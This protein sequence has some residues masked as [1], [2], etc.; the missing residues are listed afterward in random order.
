MDGYRLL[1]VDREVP[2]FAF[3]RSVIISRTDYDAHGSAILAHEQ[4]HIHLNHFFDLMLL[5]LIKTIHWFNPVVYALIGDLKEIHEFQADEHTL[6][7]GID[8]TQYQKLIIQKG[9]GLQRFALANSF[10]HC[11]IKK[12]IT[13]MNKSKNSKAWRWKVVTF[14]PLLALLLMAFGKPGENAQKI[15][16]PEIVQKNQ[17]DSS[18]LSIEIR[19]DGYFIN[20][21]L[22][23]LEEISRRAELW[24]KNNKEEVLILWLAVP[25][26]PNGLSE[27]KAALKKA[28]IKSID[29][30]VFYSGET[31]VQK[32]DAVP[33]F[34]GGIFAL[35][36]WIPQNIIYPNKPLIK[37]I[38]GN[39]YVNF[40]INA[41]GRVLDP[42][43]VKGIDPDLD[44]EALRIVS[45][46]PKWK[47]GLKN[48][49]AINVN[50]YMPIRVALKQ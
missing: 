24:Q 15:S 10:N 41:E 48:G 6:N 20:N 22:C 37:R 18:S 43:I 30:R 32:V 21:K 29:T 42:T 28:K 13:M 4:A 11:Q 45:Q 49:K 39:V 36:K 34:P 44:A 1:I 23:T 46:M 26:S 5:E 17:N 14:L 33:Q 9:V 3:G 19:K 8:A 16:P 27:V 38:E 47:P 35:R 2:S 50:Y 25:S 12:R 7:K 40:S 31:I